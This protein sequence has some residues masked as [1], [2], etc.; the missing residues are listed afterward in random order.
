MNKNITDGI[1]FLSKLNGKRL[2]NVMKLLSSYYVSR[3]VR[4]PVHWGK[5]TV[6]EVEPTTSCNLRCP[7]CISGLRDFTRDIGALDMELYK[8]IVD[9][10]SPELI[11]LL[12]Y[13]Q[14]EPFLNK[15]FLDFV[16]YAADRN[17]YT[18]TSS[19]G[20]YFTDDMAK[21]TVQSGLDRLIIS[22]DGTTQDIY[23]QYRIGGN[24]DK[25][26][27]GTRNI[28]K[29]KKELR[30]TTPHV[31]W[32]FIAFKHN[33]H[34]IP[35]FKKFA[36]EIGVNETGI[37]TAQV[38]GYETDGNFIPN[39]SELSRYEKLP[40]GSYQIKNDLESK[41]WRLWR[42]SVI[43]WDGKVV[44][45]CF[46]KDATHRMGNMNE[47]SFAEIWSSQPYKNFRSAVLKSRKE[48]DMCKNCTE[49]TKVWN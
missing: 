20:H 28:L 32:Q 5:P 4:R 49:G 35:E 36:K 46:D 40:D 39:N 34:Q 25:V 15:K 45:C 14:G 38:Y 22:I 17:I 11:Y 7:Q 3:I 31:I 37:K 23:S 10:L 26:I 6:I 1:N 41:C 48:I 33:E 44:P 2:L 27:E 47:Q 19:N 21:A 16:R 42:G 30:S 18:A 12:L 8:K 43:T 9:E 29:W 13:F 24:L